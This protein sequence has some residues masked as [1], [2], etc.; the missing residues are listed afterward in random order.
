[1]KSASGVSTFSQSEDSTHKGA[2][3]K[4]ESVDYYS[5]NSALSKGFKRSH[6]RRALQHS[7]L[8]NWNM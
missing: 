6:N 2:F 7:A 8:L 3:I 1:M 4:C 5:S